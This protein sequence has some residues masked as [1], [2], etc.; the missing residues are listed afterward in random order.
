MCFVQLGLLCFQRLQF[1]K[2]QSH[3]STLLTTAACSVDVA[4]PVLCNLG[5]WMATRVVCV[6]SM[7]MHLCACTPSRSSPCLTY[8]GIALQLNHQI[9]QAEAVYMQVLT[10]LLTICCR[11]WNDDSRGRRHQRRAGHQSFQFDQIRFG[12][13]KA[14]VQLKP[15]RKR[16]Q[17]ISKCESLSK[18]RPV[19]LIETWSERAVKMT[20]L[21][22]TL[23][24]VFKFC[25]ARS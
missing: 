23:S 8:T 17:N 20:R 7:R 19:A 9:P 11:A 6:P 15:I 25:N 24:A 2:A 18:Q 12:T 5:T 14:R 10:F 1:S 4:V 3:F 22:Q 16:V 13:L 21:E